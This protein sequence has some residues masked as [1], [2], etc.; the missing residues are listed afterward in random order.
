MTLVFVK[1]IK[2]VE[3]GHYGTN[4]FSKRNASRACVFRSCYIFF[5]EPSNYVYHYFLDVD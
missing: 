2:Q 3:G 5:P 4:R 1:Y